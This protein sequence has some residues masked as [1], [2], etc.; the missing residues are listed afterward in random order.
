MLPMLSSIEP[1]ALVYS[2]PEQPHVPFRFLNGGLEWRTGMVDWNGE[3]EWWQMVAW[4]GGLN[5]ELDWQT[6]VSFCVSMHLPTEPTAMIYSFT[7]AP[8]CPQAFRYI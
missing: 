1:T 6:A 8:S 3:L 4:N 7:K 5:A 2:F